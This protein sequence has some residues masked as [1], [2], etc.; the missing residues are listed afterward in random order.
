MT[1]VISIGIAFALLGIVVLAMLIAGIKSLKNGKQ[2]VKKIVTFLIPF[3]VFGVAYAI[4]G[5]WTDAAI[6]SMLFMLA[7]VVLLIAFTGLRSTF[8]I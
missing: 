2:D 7:A 4:T 1:T 6:V 8:N 3:V 5:G